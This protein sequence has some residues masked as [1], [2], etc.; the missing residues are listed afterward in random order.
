MSYISPFT[1]NVIQPTDVSYE[2]ITLTATT[3]LFWP[4]DGNGTQ[5]YAARIMD[6]TTPNTAYQLWMP[7][8]NQASVGQDALINNLGS[9]PLNVYTYGGGTLICQV[10]AGKANYIYITSNNTTSGT[11]DNISYGANTSSVSAAALAGYGLLAIS[12]TLNTVTPVTTFSTNM[13]TDSTYLAQTYVWTSGA[14]TLTLGTSASLGNS[15]YMYLR[16]AGTGALNVVCSG[17]DTI[18]GSANLY[19]NPGDSAMIVCS[20]TTFYTVGLGRN[21]N[22]AFTQLTKSVTGGNYVLTTTEA[23]NVILK[24][25]GT[26]S[27]NVTIQVPPSVQVYYVENQTVGGINNYTV[28]LTTAVSGGATATIASNLQSILICD[29]INLVN[30]NTVLS[31]SVSFSLPN[32]SVGSPSLYF[33]AETSTGIYRANSGEFDIAILGYNLFALTSTG[34]TINGTGTFSNGISGGGF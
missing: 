33:S 17:S 22:F 24:F 13:T 10:A 2:S 4:F 18:N 12:N 21:T 30:A 20:G 1:G 34:L 27:S 28:T 9:Q 8:A 7:P 14:G 26:L 29:S 11:W 6:V 3:Q 31:G 23:S 25:V 15:W 16:N 32:G 5:T 19:F